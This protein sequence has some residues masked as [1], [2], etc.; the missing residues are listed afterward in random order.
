[1]AQSIFKAPGLGGSISA[2]GSIYTGVATFRA[3]N[4]LASD[5]RIEGETIYG[6]AIRTANIIT[7]EGRKFAAAQ[8]L[9]YIGSGVQIAGSA[10]ITLAQTR[11]FAQAEASATR[12]RGAAVRDLAMKTARR[13]QDQ[14]RAALV[15]GILGATTS[16][17]L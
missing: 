1:M 13:T 4:A 3:A 15:G 16:F 5:L 6:E 10:L 8:S 7:E 14:G 9:Q 11:K 12:T 2:I 17:V